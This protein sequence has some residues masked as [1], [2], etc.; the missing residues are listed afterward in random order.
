MIVTEAPS[1]LLTEGNRLLPTDI[2]HKPTHP[3]MA[4]AVEEVSNAVQE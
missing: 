4:V 3:M 1:T 2:K